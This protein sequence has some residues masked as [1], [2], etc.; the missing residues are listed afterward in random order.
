MVTRYRE[1][2]IQKR[3]VMFLLFLSIFSIFFILILAN[4]ISLTYRDAFVCCYIYTMM[5]ALVITF[6]P[7]IPKISVGMMVIYYT[8]IQATGIPI[9]YLFAP[10]YTTEQLS[11]SKYFNGTCMD[12]YAALSLLA[13]SVSLIAVIIRSRKKPKETQQREE[14]TEV[15][16]QSFEQRVFFY[17]G[18]A[19][20]SFFALFMIMSMLTGNIVF[21]DYGVYKSWANTSGVRNYSQIGYWLA[22]VFICVGGTKKQIR[23]S[24]VIFLMP[25]TILVLSGNRND[26][27]FPL[28]IGIGIYYMRYKKLP[29][30]VLIASAVF[31]LYISPLI[32]QLR[33]GLET[34]STGVFE[35]IG[36]SCY[37]LG[38]QL[39]AVSQMFSW[40]ENGEEYAYG[41]TYL[42]GFLGSLFGNLIPEIRAYFSSSRYFIGARVP[43]LGFAMT[44][45]VYFNFGVIGLLILYFLLGSYIARRENRNRNT[46]QFIVYGFTMLWLII[47]V[48]N[49]FAYSFV[50]AKVFIVLFLIAY[51][52]IGIHGRSQNHWRKY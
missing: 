21:G 46:V 14:N 6:C 20:L 9:A 27:L 15:C 24:S 2:S 1:K 40:L 11:R 51:V 13:V 8:F 16:K 52:I 33:R 38:G 50:Y 17:I 39:H 10:E 7:S 12:K 29:I 30:S 42:Y 23:L 44:A 49:A 45:E 34:I 43:N 48:R 28:L 32:I 26:I 36:E 22:S 31:V 37:E 41:L 47:L 25:S 5:F 3:D 4:V 19:L 35:S 18:F